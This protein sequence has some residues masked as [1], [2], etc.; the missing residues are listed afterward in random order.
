MDFLLFGTRS[1]LRALVGRPFPQSI[2]RLILSPHPLSIPD[3]CHRPF[4]NTCVN[5][6]THRAVHEKYNS[7]WRG[8]AEM[9]P[10][11][12]THSS[13][14]D[15]RKP[16]TAQSQWLSDRCSAGN[17][18][19][20]R[21]PMAVQ[22]PGRRQN[23][24]PPPL[25]PPRY[26]SDAPPSHGERHFGGLGADRGHPEES[27]GPPAQRLSFSK[28]YAHE[29]EARRLPERPESRRRESLT[30]SSSWSNRPPTDSEKRSEAQGLQD[31]GYYS[32]SGPNPLAQPSVFAFIFTVPACLLLTL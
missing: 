32:L 13:S 8:T 30:A 20:D 29:M 31:E 10:R 19:S 16:Q 15:A 2:R 12:I 3:A 14:N 4:L 23:A 17:H 5:L 11:H 21:L 28:R 1:R 9:D 25:P 26:V 7:A 27:R 18:H 22:V 6:S 24:A